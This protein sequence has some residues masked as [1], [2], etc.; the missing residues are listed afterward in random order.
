LF[1]GGID[2]S[3]YATGTAAISALQAGVTI[4]ASVT[5]GSTIEV[6]LEKDLNPA[7]YTFTQG[8]ATAAP[9]FVAR[10]GERS[11]RP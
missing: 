11:V 2:T 7:A 4:P 1:N 3:T 8:T 5:G 6:R 10:L 9:R